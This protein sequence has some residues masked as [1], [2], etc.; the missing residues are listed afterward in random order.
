MKLCIPTTDDRGLDGR[1][2]PHFGS[3]PYFTVVNTDTGRAEILPN[4]HAV[5]E[6]GSCRPVEHLP[7]DA[8]VVRGLGARAF[9]NL[10]RMD[11]PVLLTEHRDVSG[12]LAAFNAGELAAMQ[13]SETCHGGHHE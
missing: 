10:Q 2:S 1:I 4:R 6:H 12:V 11:I 13:T 7:A 8:V 3:A 9:A 5:H